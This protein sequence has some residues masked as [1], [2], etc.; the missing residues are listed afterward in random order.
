MPQYPYNEPIG[1]S[2]AHINTATT[3]VVKSVPGLFATFNIN[4]STTGATIEFFDNTSATAPIFI[5]TLTL[6]T[7][8]TPSQQVVYNL[9]F[10]TGLTV[11]TTGVLDILIGFR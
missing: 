6:P 9:N 5:G 1:L 10:K 8:A 4:S 11:V 7:I 2:Y 3:T